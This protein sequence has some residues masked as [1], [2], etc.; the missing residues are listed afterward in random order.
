[1][2]R[3][4]GLLFIFLFYSHFAFS[5]ENQLVY[6]KII[7]GSA[8]KV[9]PNIDSTGY[10]VFYEWG[11]FGPS[12]VDIGIWSEIPQILIFDGT[13]YTRGMVLYNSN[14]EPEEAIFSQSLQKINNMFWLPTGQTIL[15]SNRFSEF[16]TNTAIFPTV[17]PIA[18]YPA[19]TYGQNVF[20]KY[21]PVTETNEGLLNFSAATTDPESQ[22]PF[23]G[24]NQAVQ[25]QSVGDNSSK[26]TAIV[27]DS[28]LI[29][30]VLLSGEQTLNNALTFT[31]WGGQVNLVRLELNLNTN[32]LNSQQ[33]GSSM[34]SQFILRSESSAT[35]PVL[36]RA[37]I[38]RGNNTPVSN[39]GAELAM[40]ENDSLYHVYITKESSSGETE[41][42]TELY[43]YNNAFPDT[44]LTFQTKIVA[45]TNIN[46]ILNMN[47]NLYV[48]S[49]FYA[50]SHIGDTLLYQDFLGQTSSYIETFPNFPGIFDELRV[51]YSKACIYKIDANG[52]V[53][54]KLSNTYNLRQYYAS[55]S[56][57]FHLFKIEDRLAWVQSY[58]AL[59]DTIL[60]FT[61]TESDGSEQTTNMSLPAGK[62]SL[63]LWLDSDLNILNHWIMPFQNNNLGGLSINSILPYKGDTLLMQGVMGNNTTS[64]LNPFND[65]E[66]IT[67]EDVSSFFAF[68]T[69]PEIFTSTEEI[70][71]PAT[72][73]VYP[74]PASGSIRVSGTYMKQANYS[75]FDISGRVIHSGKIS[76]N[77]L[78]SIEDLTSGMY[79][80]SV[81]SESGRKTAKFVVK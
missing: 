30:Y 9:V 37:G 13:T 18:N 38:V 6:K 11:I 40:S 79:I 73:K 56:Q 65:T 68:Y 7:S 44:S 26:N 36:W 49:E 81:D 55:N 20:F 34:G 10:A 64:D 50:L 33:I 71:K 19:S 29:S 4:I 70:K 74:N 77:E 75:I 35:M 27:C 25:P 62:G 51:A 48:S 42:L 63:I 32:A 45:R 59:D 28:V 66:L 12:L 46:A 22:E 23:S 14:F 5:Q 15:N 1:M 54:R 24:Y 3:Y 60:E 41:W 76:Q 31:N 21:D 17:P 69:V 57:D 80:L 72:L 61:Y 58:F 78:I 67:V 53:N 43:A 16:G 2:Y 39:S 52:N 8:N 47:D